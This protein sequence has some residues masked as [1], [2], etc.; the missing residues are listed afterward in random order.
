MFAGLL[1]KDFLLIK[2]YFLW[3]LLLMVGLY[4]VV[5]AF[6]AYHDR[7]YIVM[8]PIFFVYFF[9][10]ALLPIVVLLLLR[11]EEKGHYWLHSTAGG[12]KLLLSKLLVG[13]FVFIIS[14]VLIDVLALFS[15][16]VVIPMDYIETPGSEMPY[17]EGWLLNMGIT[18]G[19]LYFTI[20]GLFLWSIYHSLNA[21]PMLRKVR[22]LIVIAVYI[23]I[24]TLTSKL[25]ELSF[26]Q[27]WFASWTVNIGEVGETIFGMSGMQMSV[28]NN[29]LQVWPVL[30]TIIFHIMLFLAAAWL[31]NR[32]VEV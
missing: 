9:H 31:L 10:A 17:V 23:L 28:I 13:S 6:G 19:A 24:Q 3:W 21:Y 4:I 26:V 20:W 7:F 5:A 1:K 11:A 25:M 32:K 27:K 8:A 14:L 16:N 12:G 2:N 30:L 29:D 18:G 15:L 22:W